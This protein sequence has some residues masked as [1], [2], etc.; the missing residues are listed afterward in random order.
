MEED[1]NVEKSELDLDTS[2]DDELYIALIK[3]AAKFRELIDLIEKRTA[4]I[5]IY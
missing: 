1:A 5:N 2:D 4:M 3:A